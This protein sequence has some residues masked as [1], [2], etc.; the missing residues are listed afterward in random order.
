MAEPPEFLIGT[1]D[2]SENHS[3]PAKQ[4]TYPNPNGHKSRF[5]HPPERARFSRP[6]PPRAIAD[7]PCRIAVRV[8]S[9]PRSGLVPLALI[10]PRK[11][12]GLSRSLDFTPF[13]PP[14]PRN[15]ESPQRTRLPHPPCRLALCGISRPPS[16]LVPLALAHPRNELSACLRS[17]AKSKTPARG[18]RYKNTFAQLHPRNLASPPR[19]SAPRPPWQIAAQVISRPSSG[20]APLAQPYPRKPLVS[21]VLQGNVGASYASLPL[22]QPHPRKKTSGRE[23]IPSVNDRQ[24]NSL[25]LALT[26]PRKPLVS[27]VLQ[28]NVGASYA[29]LPLALAHPRNEQSART[30]SAAKSKRPAGGRRY[31]NPPLITECLIANLELEF[32]LTHAKLSALKISLV[33]HGD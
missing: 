18:R 13:A 10:H 15:L 5:S 29:S 12:S 24:T 6:D 1:I 20:L 26:Y 33:R 25:P 4:T 22:A 27:G 31:K 19:T 16:S 3:T 23:F 7:S 2:Q 14:H 32:G 28:G 30:R 11:L 21:G 17:A 8:I 9:R